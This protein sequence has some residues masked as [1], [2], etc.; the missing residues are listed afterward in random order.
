MKAE[1]RE[2]KPPREVVVTMSEAEREL[3]ECPRCSGSGADPAAR[4]DCSA[5]GGDG[6]IDPRWLV[7]YRTEHD[8]EFEDRD[9]R[10]H[11]P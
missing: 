3:V 4:G 10:E 2:P 8:D 5:C 9:W 7:S 6:R 11:L 1:R